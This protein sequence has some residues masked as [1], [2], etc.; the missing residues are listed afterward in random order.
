MHRF[1]FPPLLLLTLA[2]SA[3][4]VTTTTVNPDSAVVQDV[5]PDAAASDVR[6]P[7]VPRVD[8]PVV[9]V[10]RDDDVAFD[11]V[12]PLDVIYEDVARLPPVDRAPGCGAIAPAEP[13]VC[14]AMM[15]GN[16]RRDACEQCLPCGGGGSWGGRDSGG[17]APSWDAGNCCRPATEACDGDDLA[18]ASCTGL[19]YAGGMLACSDGCTLDTIR[20]DA[21]ASTAGRGV[22]VTAPVQSRDA[23]ELALA[24]N[25]DLIALAWVERVGASQRVDVA[26][27]DRELRLV[28]SRP[29]VG[30]PGARRVALV[31]STHG[32]LLALEGELGIQLATL[33]R[34]GS[35]DMAG[36][37]VSGGSVPILAP[38][39]EGGALLVFRFYGSVSAV[40]VNASA[41]ASHLGTNVFIASREAEY[42]SAAFT[43]DGWLVAMRVDDVEVARVGL[44]LSV[45]ARLR[46]AGRRSE[47]PQV[48]WDGSRAAMT[49]SDF[50]G[51]MAVR[52]A[53]LTR[54][55]DLAGPVRTLASPVPA[56]PY[57]N[58]APVANIGSDL[59]VLLGT[60]TG[61]TGWAGRLD[62][63]R[64]NAQALMRAESNHP[65]TRGPELTTR[66][67]VAPFV[68]GT[69]VVA[70]IGLGTPRRIGLARLRP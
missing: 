27:L 56:T 48:A 8:G 44:D 66:Y 19:G 57:A 11:R 32:F 3:C 16:G 7:D 49:W 34:D 69:A 12:E 28:A 36:S 51:P 17:P 24:T 47:Y 20:C 18:G 65:V 59:A 26:I 38:G 25:G 42:G 40:R 43:G 62:L 61:G 10:V 39:P 58:I 53:E 5:R 13:A 63:A 60:H 54:D 31:G 22:C 23:Q 15:C 33:R 35:V 64:E 67:R 70:W 41:A 45:G 6:A 68:D 2:G 29:C 9:D 52:I 50:N 14:G 4:A 30:F 21:C 46:P 55:G 1:S 37:F